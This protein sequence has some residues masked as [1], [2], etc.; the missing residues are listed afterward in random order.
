MVILLLLIDLVSFAQEP[1]I[2]IVFKL[3][4]IAKEKFFLETEFQLYS[5]FTPILSDSLIEEKAIIDCELKNFRIIS[6]SLVYV[7]VA[8]PFYDGPADNFLFHFGI[9]NLSAHKS[10]NIL[11]RLQLYPAEGTKIYLQNI[12]FLEGTYL[13]DECSSELKYSLFLERDF[14]SKPYTDVIVIPLD[15]ASNHYFNYLS[16]SDFLFKYTCTE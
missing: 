7:V 15:N 11:I 10:M 6:D 16:V 2:W 3:S 4:D 12:Q 13:Y 1:P 14:Y 8:P 5:N 9:K